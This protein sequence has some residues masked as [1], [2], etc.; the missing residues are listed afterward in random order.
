[1]EVGYTKV[2][3][4]RPS[5]YGGKKRKELGNQRPVM[6]YNLQKGKKDMIKFIKFITNF[7]EKSIVN[8]F[9]IVFSAQ[10]R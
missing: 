4:E 7:V 5:R 3:L 9:Y 8:P 1:L 2:I 6:I 10:V